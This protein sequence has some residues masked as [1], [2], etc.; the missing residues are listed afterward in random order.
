MI[1]RIKSSN[2]LFLMDTNFKTTTSVKLSKVFNTRDLAQKIVDNMK[3]TLKHLKWEVEEYD[4]TVSD[5]EIIECIPTLPVN[6]LESKIKNIEVYAKQ[7]EQRRIYLNHMLSQVDQEISDIEHAAEFYQLNA[8][9]GYKLYKL[10]R[11][12]RIRRR[13]YKNEISRISI[14]QESSFAEYKNGTVSKRIEGLEH[15]KYKPRVLEELFGA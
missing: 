1:Y 13:E 15:R 6:N 3:K 2:G 12:A 8:A 10:L 9:R 7:L 14:I 5:A 11:D 4:N